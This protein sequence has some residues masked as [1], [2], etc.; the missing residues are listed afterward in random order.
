M[1]GKAVIVSEMRRPK[2]GGVV[3]LLDT[4]F[5]RGSEGDEGAQEHVLGSRQKRY[6]YSYI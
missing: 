5:S 4:T 6:A 3:Y 2:S 1:A